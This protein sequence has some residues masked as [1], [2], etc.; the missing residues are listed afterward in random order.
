M[1][2]AAA[3]VYCA[4]AYDKGWPT[5]DGAKYPMDANMNVSAFEFDASGLTVPSVQNT[6]ERYG[7]SPAEHVD[8]WFSDSL[9]RITSPRL[10]LLRLDGDLQ[11]R[12]G[13][14]E[15][16][17]GACEKGWW[18]WWWFGGMGWGCAPPPRRLLS[19][20]AALRAA[21]RCPLLGMFA[22]ECGCK[23]PPSAPQCPRPRSTQITLE[24]LY[25]KLSPGACIIFDDWNWQ[26]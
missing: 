21:Q 18:W 22:Q 7:V 17:A 19:A 25:D 3:T 9:T 23:L 12:S 16:A 14:G 13:G 5:L 11:S 26:V 1:A 8:G 6:F 2:A 10:A 4:D 24:A 15:G 20:S